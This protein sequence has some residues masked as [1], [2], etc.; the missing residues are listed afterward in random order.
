M[1]KPTLTVLN[2]YDLKGSA[3]A[4]TVCISALADRVRDEGAAGVLSYRF[5]V[6][7]AAGTAR[8]VVDY[9]DPQ[10]WIDHHD[11][12]MQWPEMTALHGVARLAE[13]T[14]LGPVPAAIRDWLARSQLTAALHM[15]YEPAAGFTRT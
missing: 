7:E 15:G 2:V 4:F 9:A 6:N 12:S 14:F 13:A 1:T 10:G 11:I 3:A 5:F 8:A